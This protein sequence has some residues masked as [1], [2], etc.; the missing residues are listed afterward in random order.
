MQNR[1]H[2]C[3]ELRL[4]DAGKRVQLSGWMDSV[5]IV[6][7][8]LA[9]VILRDFYGTTQVVIENEENDE[10]CE[11]PRQGIH[12]FRDGHRARARQQKPEASHRRHRDR[13]DGDRA[14]WGRCR[15]N[16]LPFEINR[17]READES[18]RLKYRYLDLRNPDVKKPT[19]S[20]AA[21][22]FPLCARL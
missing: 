8:N 5:R 7:A 20:C 16:E 14:C 22:L 19:S 6:S 12:D 2:T 18:Q 17:S 21:T 4:S 9:F 3:D 15:Y 13:A 1:T 10:H 11:A